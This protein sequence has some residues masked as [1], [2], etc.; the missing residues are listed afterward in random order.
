MANPRLLMVTGYLEQAFAPSLQ[1][2]TS[3]RTELLGVLRLL[4]PHAW[5]RKAAVTGA[6]K[7]RERTV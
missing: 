7:P 3:Q 5:H 6:G 4:P 2:F 1:A